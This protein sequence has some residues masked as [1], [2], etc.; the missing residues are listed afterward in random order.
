M[1]RLIESIGASAPSAEDETWVQIQLDR[2]E[3]ELWC[4]MQVMDRTHSLGVAR[5]L[6]AANQVVDRV[7][8]AAALLHDVGKADPRLN[9][10]ERVGATLLGR[11][12]RRWTEYLDHE[13]VGARKCREVG[14]DSKVADLIEGKGDASSVHRLRAADDL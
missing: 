14:V 3:Y 2:T 1:R 12:T 7:E 10:L 6:L 11:R 5:R 13:R 4:S 8:I 9:V